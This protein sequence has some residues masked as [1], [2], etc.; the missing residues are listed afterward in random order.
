MD[1]HKGSYDC[2]NNRSHQSKPLLDYNEKQCYSKDM[3]RTIVVE[4]EMREVSK[5]TPNTNANWSSNHSNNDRSDRLF[6]C[7]ILT[8]QTLLVITG[9]Q[10]L[11]MMLHFFLKYR[12]LFCHKD[13]VSKLLFCQKLSKCGKLESSKFIFS[14]RS[15]RLSFAWKLPLVQI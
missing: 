1:K 11:K 10:T 8:S 15:Y 13:L 12:I 5:E 4:S 2:G 7:I 14:W 6:S 9:V 3:E